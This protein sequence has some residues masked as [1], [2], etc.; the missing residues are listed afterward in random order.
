MAYGPEKASHYY[1]AGTRG[2]GVR[3]TA[4]LG[5]FF[6]KLGELAVLLQLRPPLGVAGGGRSLPW[7][8][9][10]EDHNAG[11]CSRSWRSSQVTPIREGGLH[12]YALIGPCLVG[13]YL[14][15]C[16]TSPSTTHHALVTLTK[17]RFAET[18]HP[19]PT[20]GPCTPA[21]SLARSPHPLHLFLGLKIRD[22]PL[23]RLPW[24]PV[25]VPPNHSVPL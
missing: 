13:T 17:L 4:R 16:P 20:S 21:V 1:R 14:P 25:H 10:Q 6:R 23:R 11:L 8:Q 7:M 18:S 24:L 9:C 15:D 12:C 3:S 5:L 2:G 19:L 22:F